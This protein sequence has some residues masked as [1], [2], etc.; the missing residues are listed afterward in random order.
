MYAKPHSGEKE[1]FRESWIG[2]DSQ[3]HPVAQFAHSA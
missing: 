3:T 2:P 1:S